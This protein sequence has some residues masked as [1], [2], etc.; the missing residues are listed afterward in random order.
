M[1]QDAEVFGSGFAWRRRRAR[2]SRRPGGR[3]IFCFFSPAV[4]LGEKCTEPGVFAS[5]PVVFSVVA[6]GET[7]GNEGRHIRICGFLRFCGWLSHA[8]S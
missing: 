2:A 5:G 1:G 7:G 3:G 6:E 8:L 4:E